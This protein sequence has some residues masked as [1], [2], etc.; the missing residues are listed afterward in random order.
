[1]HIERRK[2]SRKTPTDGRLEI[3]KQA[4]AKFECV[5]NTFDVDVA[6]T[7][8]NGRLGTMD[9]TC[10]GA[11]NPHVHYFIQATAL[12]TLTPGTEVDLAVDPDARI[13]R[14][15]PAK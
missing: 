12:A 8:A 14:V 7:R 13:V 10:R 1:M 6:G 2:V 9:C 11:D 4:A 15:T 5:G 3:T